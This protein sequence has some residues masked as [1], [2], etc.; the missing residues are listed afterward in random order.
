M[1]DENI[2][3]SAYL[4]FG[5][6]WALLGAST[7]RAS[8]DLSGSLKSPRPHGQLKLASTR[9]RRPGARLYLEA[10]TQNSMGDIDSTSIKRA[11]I[12]LRKKSARRL[13]PM[14]PKQTADRLTPASYFLEEFHR[15]ANAT[16]SA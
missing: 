14:F 1:D 9:A 4:G 13:T 10:F 8:N 6:G 3:N 11:T 7:N 5:L 2:L 16:S 12:H 15:M